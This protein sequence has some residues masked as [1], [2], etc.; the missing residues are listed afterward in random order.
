MAGA[1]LL[2]VIFVGNVK[3]L[4]MLY[5]ILNAAKQAIEMELRRI[6]LESEKNGTPSVS[7]EYAKGLLACKF[8]LNDLMKFL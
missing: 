6:D 1:I 4:E 5:V 2:T 7:M 3:E 8:T